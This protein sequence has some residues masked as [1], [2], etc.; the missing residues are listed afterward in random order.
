VLWCAAPA[1]PSRP[2]AG[3]VLLAIFSPPRESV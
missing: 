3:F 2:D 1:L